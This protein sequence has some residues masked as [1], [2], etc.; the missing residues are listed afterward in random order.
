MDRRKFLEGILVSPS[1]VPLLTGSTPIPPARDTT[2]R[3]QDHAPRIRNN[4][5]ADWVFQRQSKG[6]GDLGSFDRE[7]GAAAEIEPRFREAYRVEYDDSGWQIVDLP[8]TWNAHDVSDA[9]PGYW[10]GIGWYRKRFKLDS[11]FSRKRVF[12]EFEGANSVSELWLNGQ[13]IGQHK[14]GYTSFEFDVTAQARF[15]A[16]ENVLTVKVDNLFHATVPPTVKTDYAFYGGIYRDAWLRLCE[17]TYI[18]EV[19]W[20]T[21]LVSRESA[22]LHLESRMVNKTSRTAEGTLV[23]EILD[24]HQRIVE[25]I[26]SP[27]RVT[28]GDSV[29][30]GRAT[31]RLEN[32]LLWSPGSPHLY[33]I[34]TGLRVGDTTIDAVENPLGFRWFEFDPQQGFFLNGARVQI[35]GTNWHQSYPGMGNAL[36]NSRHRKDMEMIREMGANFWRTSHYPHD[37]ATIEAS[38]RLGLM[39]WEELPVNKEVGNP[40]EYIANV[41]TMAEEMIRRDRNNPSVITWGIAGEINAPAKVS[42]RVVAAIAQKYRQLDSTRPVAMH[43][44]RGDD[45]EALIDVIGLGASGET[46]AKH[47]RYPNRSYLTSE[48]AIA[49]MGRGIFGAG[50]ESEDH[51][52]EKHEEYLRLLYARNWMAGGLIWH[53]FD[54][55]GENYDTVMPHINSW[56]MAD[57]WRIP[58]DVYYLYQSQWSVTPMVHIVG[59]WTWPGEEGQTK[60]VKVYSNAEEVELFLNGTSLGKKRDATDAG[61]PH[62]PRI[63]QVPFHAGTVRALVRHGAVELSDERRTAGPA[64]H[65]VLQ[66]DAPQL[67]SGDRESIAYITA[68]VVDE[69][70]TV[71]PSASHPIAFTSYGPGELLPQTWLGYGTGL[72]WNAIAGQT[73]IAFRATDR[74]GHAVISA[75]SP[76]LGMGRVRIAV[77]EEGKRDEMEYVERFENDEP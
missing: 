34:K 42:R 63:W 43:E 21:P 49:T 6:A 44:P 7:N 64:H 48:Y 61:L 16:K 30:I 77:L 23:H 67:K 46:D 50:P 15:G 28:P 35:Q 74:T 8:H 51:A 62:S 56:G 20:T 33:Q 65:L 70:E 11:V 22:E 4:F 31:C 41:L 9:E 55:E 13:R 25:T 19:I 18:A 1:A 76:G 12:L 69:K 60:A 59:H 57:V 38:D 26:S 66:S 54:F 45:I 3:P 10:R 5:N 37:P 53:Q 52:C 40:G 24:P 17:P 73:R 2:E 27:V 71:V 32:P 75:Y 68:L 39:V 47:R 29:T 14:G 72:T 36:P 58:K